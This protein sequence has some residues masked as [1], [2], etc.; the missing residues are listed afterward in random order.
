MTTQMTHVKM[1][2]PSSVSS[3]I[4]VSDSV[5]W[6]QHVTVSEKEHKKGVKNKMT[7]PCT[8]DSKHFS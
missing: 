2:H 5:S 8:M 4:L 6:S 7:W 3:M 1:I